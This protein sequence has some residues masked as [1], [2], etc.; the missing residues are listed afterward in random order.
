MT[1]ASSPSSLAPARRLGVLVSGRGSNLKSIL[2]AA[3]HGALPPVGLVLSN[4]PGCPALALAESAGTPCLALDP[5]AF[6]GRE[7][8]DQALVILE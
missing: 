8:Y 2:E 1:L 7:E 3:E 4:K 5:K 6:P